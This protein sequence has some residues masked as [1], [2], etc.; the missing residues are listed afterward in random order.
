M[1]FGGPNY[2]LLLDGQS[3]FSRR[4]D[5]LPAAGFLEQATH[6]SVSV[7]FMFDAVFEA[8]EE[9]LKIGFVPATL[10]HFG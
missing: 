3:A 2:L 9:S 1:V 8:T 7:P 5:G 4:P 6:V 10:F